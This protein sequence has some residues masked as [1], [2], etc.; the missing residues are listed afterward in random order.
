MLC[1][2]MDLFMVVIAKKL[3][4][5]FCRYHLLGYLLVLHVLIFFQ[6][7]TLPNFKAKVILIVYIQVYDKFFPPFSVFCKTDYFFLVWINTGKVIGEVYPE[8]LW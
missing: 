3:E 2:F 7:L 4:K 5:A 1:L 8:T 6:A